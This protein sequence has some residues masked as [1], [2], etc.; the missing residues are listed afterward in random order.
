MTINVLR[1]ID[2]NARISTIHLETMRNNLVKLILYTSRSSSCS[3][4]V[5]L[6]VF[7]AKMLLFV[8]ILCVLGKFG[9][10]YL[11]TFHV[12]VLI[13]CYSFIWAEHNYVAVGVVVFPGSVLGNF[14]VALFSVENCMPFLIYQSKALIT[15]DS[16]CMLCAKIMEITLWMYY[17]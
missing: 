8:C 16:L 15:W 3:L 4:L 9:G 12:L 11:F 10:N 14:S 7:H 6:W 1:F 17:I 5:C 13:V 2:V